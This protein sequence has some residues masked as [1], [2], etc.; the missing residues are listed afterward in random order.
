MR[1]A[2]KREA[3][4]LTMVEVNHSRFAA[5]ILR[6]N[7]RINMTQMAKP[8]G[9]SKQPAHWLRTKKTKDYLQALAVKRK[10]TMADLVE[11]R[12]GGIPEEQGTWC[13]DY[14]I[15]LRFAQW[16][17]AEFSVACEDALLRIMS[18]RQLSLSLGKEGK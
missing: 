1:K 13:N 8:F 10:I 16:L 9:R 7:A 4:S 3:K 5:E 18:G 2:E 11:V 17:S 6:G 15:A 12:Q 14:R